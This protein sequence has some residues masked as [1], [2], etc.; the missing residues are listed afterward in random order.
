MSPVVVDASVVMAALLSTTS[1]AGDRLARE[2][3]LHAPHALDLE[4]V[5]VLRRLTYSGK[6]SENGARDTLTRFSLL[7]ISR[8]PHLSL[9]PRI[10]ELR[11]NASAY[12]ASYVALAE[13]LGAVLLSGDLRLAS[14]PGLRCR[15]ETIDSAT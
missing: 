15:I 1:K 7:P 4:V 2:P 9:V 13:V 14:T 10:W 8:Y 5:S 12:D 6:L 3:V 11:H